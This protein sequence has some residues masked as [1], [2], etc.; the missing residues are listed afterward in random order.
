[1]EIASVDGVAPGTDARG[2]EI[3]GD[4]S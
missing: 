1:M 3:A 2:R 4:S